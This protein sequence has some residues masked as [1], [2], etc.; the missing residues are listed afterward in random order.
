LKKKFFFS[1]DPSIY[2]TQQPPSA[3]LSIGQASIYGPMITSNPQT[4]SLRP[5]TATSFYT[6]PQQPPVDY[7]YRQQAGGAHIYNYLSM[8]PPT[9]SSFIHQQQQTQQLHPQPPQSTSAAGPNQVPTQHGAGIPLP[10]LVQ[11]PSGQIQ[12]IFPAHALQQQQQQQQQPPPSN[13]YPL[14]PDGQYVSV[15]IQNNLFYIT[16]K[17]QILLFPSYSFIDKMLYPYKVHQQFQHHQL[18]TVLIPIIIHILKINLII[19]IQSLNNNNRLHHHSNN[20]FHHLS[21]ILHHN[22]HLLFD[23]IQ[24]EHQVMFH[25]HLLKQLINHLHHHKQHLFNHLL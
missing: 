14:T 1:L 15:N 22:P 2:S 17:K 9:P 24:Q 25:I 19:I 23:Y 11:Q 4:A 7:D 20:K 12:Y 13:P 3:N 5:P 10:I 8:V 21:Q 6:Q 16:K 18:L